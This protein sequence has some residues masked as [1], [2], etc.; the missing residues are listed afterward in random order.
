MNLI[1]NLETFP[2]KTVSENPKN[3]QF[4]TKNKQFR[5]QHKLC[6]RKLSLAFICKYQYSSTGTRYIR[7]TFLQKVL[8]SGSMCH[9]STSPQWIILF[10]EL[11]LVYRWH[12]RNYYRP[13]ISI[14]KKQK[15]WNLFFNGKSTRIQSIFLQD[16]VSQWTL[17]VM[18]FFDS[19]SNASRCWAE[20]LHMNSLDL[21]Q[22]CHKSQS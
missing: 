8:F 3:I 22:K 1:F 12:L 6:K 14:G 20:I 5:E 7:C 19:F 17:P 13:H 18:F 2:S 9:R 11:I 21:Y 10:S 15:I 4:L 16:R